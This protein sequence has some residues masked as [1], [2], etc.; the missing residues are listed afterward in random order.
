[1]FDVVERGL[2]PHEHLRQYGSFE[3]PIV[4]KTIDQYE[5]LVE[6]AKCAERVLPSL[7]WHVGAMNDADRQK[8]ADL[9]MAVIAAQLI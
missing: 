2:K 6:L 4:E 1:M 3:G 7:Q 8:V 9:E 5:R